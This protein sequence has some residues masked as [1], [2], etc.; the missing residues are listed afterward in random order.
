MDIPGAKLN[1]P[2]IEWPKSSS[3]WS[4]PVAQTVVAT[5]TNGLF[6][7]HMGWYM[8]APRHGPVWH[9]WPKHW[10]S[11]YGISVISA[12]Y[13][14]WCQGS[15]DVFVGAAP[16]KGALWLVGSGESIGDDAPLE[17]AI[18]VQ[19]SGGVAVPLGAVVEGIPWPKPRRTIAN[20][21][22]GIDKI[23]ETAEATTFPSAIRKQIYGPD[24]LILGLAVVTA[25]VKLE[26]CADI[27]MESPPDETESERREQAQ[28]RIEETVLSAVERRVGSDV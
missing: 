1:R 20:Y 3:V 6:V 17:R 12:I 10:L 13:G 27:Y 19:L 5:L 15:L 22:L 18:A 7:S 4:Y 14:L 8:D 9:R 26:S 25:F 11:D 2:L 28:L 24:A 21:L 16:S 23:R